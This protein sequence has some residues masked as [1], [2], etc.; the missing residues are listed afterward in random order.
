MPNYSTLKL[1]I[2]SRFQGRRGIDKLIGVREAIS[3]LLAISFVCLSKIKFANLLSLTDLSQRSCLAMFC[4]Q[5]RIN[6][7]VVTTIH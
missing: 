2:C 4:V 7:V 3:C 6:K 5:S 1:A